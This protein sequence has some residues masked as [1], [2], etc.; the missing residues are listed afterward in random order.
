[1]SE[2]VTWEQCPE[3]RRLAAV[4]WLDGT[5]VEFDCPNGC[6]L[7]QSRIAAAFVSWPV[8]AFTQ[9][10]LTADPISDLGGRSPDPGLR[11]G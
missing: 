11:S 8:T 2:R 7:T 6:S 10:A 4:G 1:V 5:L 3:C 9:Q